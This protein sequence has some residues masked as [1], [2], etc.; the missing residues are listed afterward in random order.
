MNLVFF[1]IDGTLATGKHVPESAAEG[2]RLLRENGNLVFIC[3]GRN[4][5]YAEKNFGQ[6]ADGFICCNGRLAVKGGEVLY[7]HPLSDEQIREIVK[8]M[9]A[10]GA[11]YAFLGTDEGYYGGDPAG[12]EVMSH[13]QNKGFVKNGLAEHMNVYTFD[14]YLGTPD[15]ISVIQE[16]LDGFAIANPHGPHPSAD[17]TVLGVDKGTA[18]VHVAEVLG[19]PLENTYGF[20]D[21]RNDI[22]MLKAVG[23]G[24]AMGNAIDE[25]KAAAEYVTTD[26]NDN[27]VWNGLKHYGLI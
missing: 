25:T 5:A 27:G 8:R 24:I 13:V 2:L 11:G 22:C 20:G 18:L 9:D 21:G 3:T 6:Y 4:P 15:R 10:V 12:Y 16:A 19:V 26:I 23:H 1:D 17:I 14:A 7:S